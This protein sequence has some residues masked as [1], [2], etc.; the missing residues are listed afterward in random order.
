MVPFYVCDRGAEFIIY[1]G[2]LINVLHFDVFLE[3]RVAH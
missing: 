2:K 1:A 3:F